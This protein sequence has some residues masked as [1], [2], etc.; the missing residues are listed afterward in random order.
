MRYNKLVLL[1]SLLVLLGLL[2]MACAGPAGP[3]GPSGS[4]GPPGA[5]GLPGKAGE[6]GARGPGGERGLAGDRGPAGQA[7]AAGAALELNTLRATKVDAAPAID[8]MMDAAWLKATPLLV[9]VHNGANLVNGSTTVSLRAL[10]SGNNIY[11]LAQYAD[12]T[13]SYQRSPWQ[14]QADGSWKLR[15][16]PNASASGNNLYYEDKA[17]LIWNINDSIKGFNQAGCL[18]LCH[19]GE[20]NKV[21]GN[22]YTSTTGELGDIWHWKSVRTGPVGQIDDQ[23]VD[24][25]RYDKD[26]APD[27]GRKSDAK[28]AGGYSDN[29]AADGKLPR[30]GLPGN[31]AAPPYWIMDSEKVA[32]DDSKYK[33][34]DEVPGIL[35][36]PITGDR[37]DLSAAPI[38]KDGMWTLEWTRKL[39]TGSKTDVQFTDLKKSYYFGVAIFDN[40]QVHHAWSDGGLK[41]VFEPAITTG[42]LKP[43]AVPANHTGRTT[44]KV[45]H[46]AGVGGAPKFP[47]SVSHVA[48]EDVAKSCS[49]CH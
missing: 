33:A 7:G 26:K 43:P 5:A 23:Y 24:D 25:T 6:A 3:S 22:K 10:Y 39:D 17:A 32:F 48:F 1:V 16:D 34:G 46:E 20:N 47:T 8:G 31:K 11:F 40:A 41:M 27:A 29:V 2:F 45:C 9:T 18:V 37:G 36:S 42:L 38:W 28:T 21:Y 13:Q 19:P 30:Y 14:K 49:R 35:I 12:K 44:C 15:T 4:Q